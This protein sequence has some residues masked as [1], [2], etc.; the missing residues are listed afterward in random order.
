[1]NPTTEK[2]GRVS[3]TYPAPAWAYRPAGL[4]TDAKPETLYGQ[5]ALG[6]AMD[7]FTNSAARMGW[8]TPSLTEG[9]EY[10]LVRLSYDYWL[11]IT[12]YRNHWIT[13]KIVD[14]PAQDMVRAWPK[15]TSDIPPDDLTR[16]DRAIQRTGTKQ[17]MLQAL[18]W[19][20]LFG[21]A[22]ALIVIDGH[23]KILDE[24]LD[25]DEVK[26][27]SY[28]GLIPFDR[29]VG[30][31]PEA[32]LCSDITRPMDFNLPE[33]Y[34][35]TDVDGH[36]FRVHSSRILRFCGPEV[37]RP[38]YDAQQWWGISVVEPAYEEIRKRDNMSWTIMSL[39]FRASIL[40][41][42]IPDLAPLMS[43]VG[44]SAKIAQDFYT[45]MNTI[46]EMMSNQGLIL[47]GKDSALHHTAASF[48]GVSDIYQQ[49][50]LDIAG[51]SGYTV[52]RL[53]GRTITGLAQTNDADERLYEERIQ[54]DQESDL[55][56]QHDKLF[57][58][59]AMSEWG[60]APDDLGY[61]YPSIRVMTEEEKADL[62]QKSSA[63]V[64]S[65]FDGGLINKVQALRELKQTSDVT[66]IFTNI[67]DK[68]IEAAQKEMEQAKQMKEL[69]GAAGL[70]GIGGEGEAGEE[71][72][73]GPEGGGEPH[74]ESRGEEAVTE[75]NASPEGMLKRAA[76]QKAADDLRT[77]SGETFRDLFEEAMDAAFRESEHPRDEGGKFVTVYHGTSRK[78]AESILRRGIE[79]NRKANHEETQRGMTY[80]T[81]D[82]PVAQHFAELYHHDPVIVR[83]RVPEAF[84]RKMK[85]DPY[86][87][88]PIG[89]N[90][91]LPQGYANKGA[92]PKEFIEGYAEKVPHT[93]AMR[94]H[95]KTGFH[96]RNYW[97][98]FGKTP[99]ERS[100]AP[101]SEEYGKTARA[102]DA[103]IAYEY[104]FQGIP[105]AVEYPAGVRRVLRN[106]AGEVV[107]DR[108][109]QFD[110]GEIP[111]TVGR[112]GDAIDVIVGND[113]QASH[114][115]VV[116]MIDLGPD[117]EAREDEDKVC[118][119][120]ST[121]EEARAAF[122]TMYPE[123]FFGGMADF[124][125]EDFCTN[126]LSETGAASDAQFRESEHPRKASGPEAGQFTKKGSGGGGSSPKSGSGKSGQLV[127][128]PKDREKWPKHIRSLVVP[129]AWKDVRYNPNPNAVGLMVQG[130][131]AN[132]KVQSLYSKSWKS[133]KADA[134]FKRTKELRSKLPAIQKENAADLKSDNP[135]VRENAAITRLIMHTGMRVGSSEKQLGKVDTFGAVKLEGRH[136][137]TKRGQVMVRFVGKHG[138]VNTYPISDPAIAK[139]LLK[140][141][142]KVGPRERLFSCKMD[143]DLYYCSYAGVS[144]YI[145]ALDGGKFSAKDFRTV[146]GTTLAIDCVKAMKAPANEK[147]LK[148]AVKGISTY[149]SERLN[150]TPKMAFQDYIDPAVWAKWETAA[151]AKLTRAYDAL[152]ADD[153]DLPEIHFGNVEAE[154]ALNWRDHVDESE[155]DD[156]DQVD[157]SFEQMSGV[158]LGGLQVD[159]LFDEEGEPLP[160]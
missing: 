65:A 137:V 117:V 96:H 148:A 145:K 157:G 56:P 77:P 93:T 156:E 139:D 104:V 2:F 81:P 50:Q 87:V 134:K 136:V 125:V 73:G 39:T 158:V 17:R 150:N 146:T 106:P 21:G 98:A 113:D 142:Q 76:K 15:L 116:D 107:Y 143:G 84:F 92:I 88:Q 91:A 7:M 154:E 82:F 40:G 109:M 120:F 69:M 122:L 41:L 149:V 131:A 32:G 128:A 140:R 129:P 60:E 48:P 68:D 31:S 9:T 49:F 135:M 64:I 34:R 25:L 42:T 78:N 33:M 44:A 94:R 89:A 51:A 130:R 35:V 27:G 121:P 114:V 127:A 3:K 101:G 67:T 29:W 54:Q 1:M 74:G 123:S 115:Y 72:E 144:D 112:D 28:R 71:P 46:N 151:G 105:V 99:T 80:V 53:F 119:G 62:A 57:E 126:W 63:V 4:M 47:M 95:S 24:P 147:E 22:G 8:G 90:K 153:G 75:A 124:A 52:S 108:L 70:V 14:G 86:L 102:K 61:T 85:K 6:V 103:I 43:G 111:N 141:A 38:E 30:V 66:G 18:K 5:G 59:I 16:F 19:G 159:D 37:P 55:R 36:A 110:Y 138:K 97:S 152:D 23:E 118:I 13:R 83:A 26:P 11:L 133:M 79:P 132:G 45:R 160:A 100:K 58:V 155:G 10:N 20:R 12:L